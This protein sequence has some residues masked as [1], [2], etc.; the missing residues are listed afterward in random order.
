MILT[1]RV[2]AEQLIVDKPLMITEAGKVCQSVLSLCYGQEDKI[3]SHD[4]QTL[5]GELGD[6]RKTVEANL[7]FNRCL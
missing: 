5:V 6:L 1:I 2:I 3:K 4:L 7:E